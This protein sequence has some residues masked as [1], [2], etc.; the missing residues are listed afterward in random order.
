MIQ[1][2]SLNSDVYVRMIESS[3]NT[4]NRR[5][6]IS[7]GRMREIFTDQFVLCPNNMRIK[8]FSSRA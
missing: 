7:N 6:N 1:E 2:R 5:F 3:K 4:N 8:S